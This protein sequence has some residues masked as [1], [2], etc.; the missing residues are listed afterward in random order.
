MPGHRPDGKRLDELRKPLVPDRVRSIGGQSFSFLPHRFLRDGFLSSLDAD[1]LRLYVFL[2]LAGNRLGVSFYGVDAI[3]TVLR[4]PLEHFL[5]ARQA[6]MNKDLVAFDGVRFQ[7]L[8]LPDQ[9][10]QALSP[11][12][13]RAPEDFEENDPATIRAILRQDL[14]LEP[15]RR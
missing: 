6:L 10:S 4:L 12:R 13:L 11:P 14:G 3:C 2:L 5:H 9:P 1:E 7:V 8:S 15:P